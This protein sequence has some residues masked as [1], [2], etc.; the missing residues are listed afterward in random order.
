MVENS[1]LFND[2]IYENSNNNE[3]RYALGTKGKNTLYC[4]GIN[5][6]T[7]TPEK[8]DRTI[9]KVEKICREKG[10]DSFVMLNIYPIR[11]TKPGNLPK[12]AAW[13]EHY[14]NVDVILNLIKDNSFVWAAWGNSINKRP[15]LAEC[16]DRILS[17]IQGNKNVHLVRMGSLT[18]KNQPRHP[19]FCPVTEFESYNPSAIKKEGVEENK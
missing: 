4:I 11:A 12:K 9:K 19:L 2:F 10:F 14:R 8:Y 6:S 13:S 18:A 1:G 5:P 17:I 3:Y 15:W 16:K 7:A